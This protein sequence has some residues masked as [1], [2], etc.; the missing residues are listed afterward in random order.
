MKKILLSVWLSLLFYGNANAVGVAYMAVNAIWPQSNITVCWINPSSANDVERGFVRRAVERTWV[1]N[2]QIAFVG[3]DTVCPATNQ[4][5]AVRIK[6]EDAAPGVADFGVKLLDKDVG[7]RLNFTFQNW[8]RSKSYQEDTCADVGGSGG[9]YYGVYSYG[10]NARY[11][12]EGQAIH[13]FGHVLGMAHDQSAD[14]PYKSCSDQF[15]ATTP[16]A[17]VSIWDD[18]AVMNYC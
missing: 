9:Y 12:I 14:L 10:A 11:C 17:K 6:I 16:L 13:E 1:R 8:G 18:N 5:N 2:S 3:W 4:K 7:V 15:G